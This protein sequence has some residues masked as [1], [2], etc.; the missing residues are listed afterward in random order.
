MKNLFCIA[1]ALGV[2][3]LYSPAV[4]AQSGGGSSRD[5]AILAVYFVH[6][7]KAQ[8]QVY[9]KTTSESKGETYM[10]IVATSVR[11]FRINCIKCDILN[12]GAVEPYPA[13]G[14]ATLVTD[15][16]LKKELMRLLKAQTANAAAVLQK[17]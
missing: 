3:F 9:K 11:F 6:T 17:G 2:V 15:P 1:V 8:T 7:A 14:A 13:A 4:F 10:A 16:V 12:R 5:T